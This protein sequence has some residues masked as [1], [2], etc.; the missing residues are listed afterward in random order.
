MRDRLIGVFAGLLLV[1]LLVAQPATGSPTPASPSPSATSGHAITGSLPGAETSRK[2]RK[3]G[4]G[5]LVI[6]VGG[7][8]AGSPA[9]VI[10]KGPRLGPRK[11]RKFHKK[12]TRVGKV[13]IRKARPGKYRIRMKRVIL[14]RDVE[15]IRA[16][17]SA[18]PVWSTK[19]IRVKKGRSRSVNAFYGTVVN[20]NVTSLGSEVLQVLGDPANPQGVLV[21]GDSTALI[22]KIV[23]A[24]PSDLLPN[25]L[26]SHVTNAEASGGGTLLALTAADMYEAVPNMILGSTLTSS[27]RQ[28]RV[29][30]SCDT[31]GSGVNPYVEIEDLYM[32]GGW[33]STKVLFTKIPTGADIRLY[34][35]MRAGV[36]IEA[37]AGFSCSLNLPGFKVQGMAGLVPVYGKMSPGA[38]VSI[39][40]SSSID[41]GVKVGA[42]IGAKVKASPL[43]VKP[44]FSPYSPDPYLEIQGPSV[45]LT[46]GV[47]LDFELGIGIGD[48]G[49]L[50][51]SIGNSLDY[52]MDGEGCRWN[53]TLGKLGLGGKFGPVSVSWSLND[54]YNK[55]L[56]SDPECGGAG[57][58]QDP[59]RMR[60]RISWDNDTDVDLHTWDVAGEHAWYGSLGG[61]PDSFLVTDI[62]PEEG[63]FG[64]HA[65]E[66]FETGN[67]GR[68]FT[69]GI[70]LYSGDQ[71]TARIDAIDPGGNVR[72][73]NV[74]LDRDDP[75]RVITV[76]PAGAAGFDPSAPPTDLEDWELEEWDYSADD[77]CS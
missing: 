2:R 61:I 69:I 10:V 53:M 32:D 40:S 37:R 39:Q 31:G 72:S 50:H 12:I 25:G 71:A 17:A 38:E 11:K 65:E 58:V 30:L 18:E 24:P 67:F 41:A 33:T 47:K 29:G 20:P 19:T 36:R 35:T 68:T 70:C 26:L 77:W 63:D 6:R 8:P 52:R 54:G 28:S 62:I 57:A 16:G 74:S 13:V 42:M 27:L 73:T 5:R 49:S 22:G 14:P 43:T 23:S 60:A 66:F 48:V 4:F 21:A 59:P 1:G 15:T 75:G 45:A 64:N 51:M 44:H 56:W 55:E 46:A 9:K 7:L 34:L 3:A 76:T